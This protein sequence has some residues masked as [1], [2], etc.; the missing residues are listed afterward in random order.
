MQARLGMASSLYTALRARH[1]PTALHSLR[2]AVGC[3]SWAMHL[4]LSQEERDQIELSALLHDIGKIGVPDQVLLKPGKLV[5]EELL[6]MDSHRKIRQEILVGFCGSSFLL[7]IVHYTSAWFDGR[8]HGFE[9]KGENLPLGSRMI[10][11]VDAFDA[12]TTDHVYRR[13]MSRERAM[14]ELFEC[15]GTQFDPLL[16]KSFCNLIATDKLQLNIDVARRWLEE[17]EP[18]VANN[19]WHLGR[20]QPLATEATPEQQ[21]HNQLLANMHDGVVFVDARMKILHWNASVERLTGITAE[22]VYQKQWMP[23]LVGMCDEKGKGVTDTD[24]PVAHVLRCRVQLLRRMRIRGRNREP[25]SVD[26]HLVPVLNE[27]GD[28]QGATLLMH[29]ASSQITLEERVQSLHEK[30][31][32]DPLTKVANR[33]EFDSVHEQFVNTHLEQGLS[34]SLIMCDLDH[35]KQVNDTYGHQA[36]D[37]ALISFAALLQRSCRPGDLVARYG[38][39]EFVLLYADCDNATATKRA[40]EIR[41]Q[42]ANLPQQALDQRCIT[43]SFGVTE[44]QG[45]DTP[46]TMLRRADR[47]LLQAKDNGRNRVIQLGSGLLEEKSVSRRRGWLSWWDRSASDQVLRASLV[48]AVPLQVAAEKLRGFVADHHAQIVTIEENRVSLKIEGNNS[49]S[50]RRQSDRGMPFVLEL[51]FQETEPGAG[52]P[53]DVRRTLIQVTIRPRRSRDRRRREV[54]DRARRLLHSLKSYFMAH[55]LPDPSAGSKWDGNPGF[56]EQANRILSDWLKP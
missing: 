31:T 10:A 24:C 55:E 4:E 54:V 16:V 7:D 35:F 29:D 50:L 52:H 6:A 40:E 30:A 15:A 28:L 19:Y 8:Q 12:M 25:V 2:V 53:M 27:Q 17:I 11:I 43:A 32:R 34:C 51:E 38:G 44:I 37:E 23:S 36:G 22:S 3:S 13:A 1:A 9:L 26:V 56:L 47:A 21:F 39:E 42:W 48:T 14:A 5:G 46:E 41:R 18:Q 20:L 45:G 49:P 33:A